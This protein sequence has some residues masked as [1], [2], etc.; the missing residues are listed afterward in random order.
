MRKRRVVILGGGFGG[1]AAA[2]ALRR[3][4]GEV[5][6]VDQTNHHLFQPLLYQV[7]TAGLSGSDIAQPIRS[8]LRGQANCSIHMATAVGIDLARRI[9]RFDVRQYELDFDYLVIALGVQTNWFGHADW[10]KHALGLKS[11]DD[12]YKVRDRLLAAFERAE[13]F[14]DQPDQLQRELSVVVIGGGP[15]GVEMAGAC[16]ELARRALKPEYRMANLSQT[17]VT[18]IDAGPRVLSTFDPDL[19]ARAAADLA[20]MGVT[21]LNNTRVEEIGDRYV[22][23]SGKRYDAATIIW[24]A[25]VVAPAITRD[26]A[27][28]TVTPPVT[29]DRAGRITVGT[30]CAIPGHSHVFAVGDI[31]A[32]TDAKGIPTPGLAQG[33]MQ[34]GTHAARVILADAAGNRTSVPPFIYRDKGSMAT[35]GRSRAVAHIG[36]FKSG[37]TVAWLL[38]LAIHLLFLIDLR[39]KLTVLLKWIAAYLFYKPTSRLISPQRPA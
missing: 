29:L 31:A 26:L 1:L 5:V 20:H 11:L 19:S 13:N 12:A 8:I 28:P 27:A 9:V 15:T 14:S 33:A 7:A 25:G 18:L 10:S 22:I 39:S 2:R 3:F 34:M 37:G 35:I 23:A 36:N 17:R 21:I 38:W 6:I 16:A 24:A 32:M 30:D 4:D